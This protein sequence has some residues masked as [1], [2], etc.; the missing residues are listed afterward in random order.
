VLPDGQSVPV[1]EIAVL[2]LHRGWSRIGTFDGRQVVNVLGNVDS[3]KTNTM[4]ILARFRAEKLPEIEGRY[5]GLRVSFKG[6]SE[7]GAETG[8]SLAWAA[9]VGC[10]GVFVILSFQFRS[11][12][13]PIIVMLAIPF[14]FVGVVV[15]HLL[16]GISLSL[17]SI[18]G[19]ASLSGIVVND[20]I[21]LMLF[22]KAK[23]AAGVPVERAAAEASRMRFR[24]V[25]ITSL[26]TIAGL[27]PL[28]ME[29]NLQAQVLIPIAISICFGLLA[30]TVLVLVVLPSLYVLLADFGLT[31]K[32]S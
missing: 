25:M 2:E 9:M 28:L 27:L 11:Y 16:W 19:Y 22:L 8:S 30:S 23:R 6:E 7:K 31:E 4:G 21:L 10:I 3:L 18:M 13:E 12:I 5:P 1:A 20:S 29:R 26:T 14:A 17:P 15:G 32:P 24:A